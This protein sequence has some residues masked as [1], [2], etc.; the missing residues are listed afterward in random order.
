MHGLTPLSNE[1]V[2]PLFLVVETGTARCCSLR[3]VGGTRRGRIGG[4]RIAGSGVLS[5][6]LVVGRVDGP[7]VVPASRRGAGPRE[8]TAAGTSLLLGIDFVA[9]FLLVGVVMAVGVVAAAAVRDA[10]E[11]LFAADDAVG[12]VGAP[13]VDRGVRGF[14]GGDAIVPPRNGVDGSDAAPL[15]GA[16]DAD[17]ESCAGVVAGDFFA[18]NGVV[19][20][21]TDPPLRGDDRLSL[22]SSVRVKGRGVT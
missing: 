18:A 11:L 13:R 5:V 14:R 7:G 19:G 12:V 6:A 10:D 4:S 8:T 2:A 1:V 20:A 3:T 17:A 22:S 9:L 15:L 21:L 16:F